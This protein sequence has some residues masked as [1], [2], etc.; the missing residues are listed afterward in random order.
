MAVPVGQLAL[1]AAVALVVG[2]LAATLPA[3]R[4]ARVDVLAAIAAE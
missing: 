1:V 3:R 2:V 4:A